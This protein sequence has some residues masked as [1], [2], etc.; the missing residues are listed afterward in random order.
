MGIVVGVDHEGLILTKS[1]ILVTHIVQLRIHDYGSDDQ[2]N[3]NGELKNDQASAEEKSAPA[4]T[5]ASFQGSNGL[6]GR[7][8]KGGIDPGEQPDD[9][10]DGE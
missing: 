4:R 8:H 7:K 2:D 6:E 5:K 9:D 1:K 3:G 10:G